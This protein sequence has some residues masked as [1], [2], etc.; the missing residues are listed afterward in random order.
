MPDDLTRRVITR[1]IDVSAAYLARDAQHLAD[2]AQRLADRAATPQPG[3]LGGDAHR[4]AQ[5]AVALLEVA[6]RLDAMRQ[7][8]T[9]TLPANTPEETP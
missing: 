2:D 7:V 1:Q 6:A 8:A 9:A 4:L 5:A 3:T